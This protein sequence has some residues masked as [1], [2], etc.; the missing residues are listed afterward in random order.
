VE[1]LRRHDPS[2]PID[3]HLVPGDHRLSSP[4]HMESLRQLVVEQV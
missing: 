3:L 1:V 2:F 4:Q